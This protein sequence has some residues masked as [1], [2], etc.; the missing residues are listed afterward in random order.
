MGQ[1]TIITIIVNIIKKGFVLG[2]TQTFTTNTNYNF[3]DVSDIE[4]IEKQLS[5]LNNLPAC[6][7]AYY[8]AL[9][10]FAILLFTK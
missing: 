10:C 5:F 9:P 2:N 8:W 7:S 6:K 1:I 4:G 3:Y